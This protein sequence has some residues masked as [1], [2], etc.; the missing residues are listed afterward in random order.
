MYRCPRS[1]S[2]RHLAEEERQQQRADMRA[3]HVGVRHD[4]DAVVAQLADVEAALL[5]LAAAD[6][7]AQRGDQRA[8]FLAAQHA[9]EAGALDVQDLAL[10]RQDRLELAVA[11]LLG[12]AAGA[13]TLD[14]EDLALRRDRVPG[15][16]PACRAASKYPARPCA[17][18]VRAPC[19]PPRAPTAA[20]I[21][22]WTM[23]LASFG[24]VSNQCD[25]ASATAAC[26]TGCTS[27]D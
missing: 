23:P 12:R 21:T 1:I 13:V 15:S 17:A 26:T 27:D 5:R 4:D 18:S 2:S 6:A 3:V 11:S 19:A 25:T 20:S 9:V 22:F 10:Q 8:D 14:D 24:C 16:R 7:G